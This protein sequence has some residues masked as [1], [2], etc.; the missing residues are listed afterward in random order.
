MVHAFVSAV[1][2]NG[3]AS[4]RLLSVECPGSCLMSNMRQDR[5]NKL[6]LTP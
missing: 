5:H 2:L 6:L 3:P 1:L 4:R